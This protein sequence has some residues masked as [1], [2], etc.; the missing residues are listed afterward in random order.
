MVI[1]KYVVEI[2]TF[3]KRKRGGKRRNDLKKRQKIVVTLITD[4]L[5]PRPAQAVKFWHCHS[6]FAKNARFKHFQA[7]ELRFVF[8]IYQVSGHGVSTLSDG[9]DDVKKFCV[10]VTVASKIVKGI[11]L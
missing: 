5:W 1:Y 9:F 8:N 2:K 7:N 10:C 6:V 11:S 4:I 3:V